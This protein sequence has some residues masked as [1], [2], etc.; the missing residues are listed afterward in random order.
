[1]EGDPSGEKLK[2]PQKNVL[3]VLKK[4]ASRR[5]LT[6]SDVVPRPLVVLEEGMPLDLVH[7]VPAQA[8][9]SVERDAHGLMRHFPCSWNIHTRSQIY[10]RGLPTSTVDAHMGCA[11]VTCIATF[12]PKLH[13]PSQGQ[14][15]EPN[16][17]L[18]A[19]VTRLLTAFT[20]LLLGDGR[21]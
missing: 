12:L 8:H 9:L 1:M 20:R 4:N 15:A 14:M 21:W 5:G 2:T 13:T 19:G 10:L 6:L 3:N 18:L 7:A 11:N 17:G 16:K